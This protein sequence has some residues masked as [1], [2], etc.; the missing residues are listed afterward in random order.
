M[1]SC[2]A[3]AGGFS[4]EPGACYIGAMIAGLAAFL[5]FAGA[6][7]AEFRRQS[8]RVMRPLWGRRTSQQSRV[9]CLAWGAL[10]LIVCIV[11]VATGR[12]YAPIADHAF[13]VICSAIC[14]LVGT[15]LHELTR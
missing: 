4:P 9:V 6:I 5:S 2:L 14:L 15:R 11:L 3:L 13:W 8:D 1:D 10:E 7:D 12:G